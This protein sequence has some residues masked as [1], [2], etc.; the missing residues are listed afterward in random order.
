MLGGGKLFGL[1]AMSK[2]RIVRVRQER[3]KNPGQLAK[4]LNL[5]I[6]CLEVR[7]DLRGE[8][9][10]KMIATVVVPVRDKFLQRPFDDGLLP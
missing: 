1:G 5:C 4:G 3:A 6:K 10:R 7:T 8:T 2:L 9:L